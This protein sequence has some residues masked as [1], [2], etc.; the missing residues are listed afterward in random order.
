MDLMKNPNIHEYVL[1]IIFFIYGVDVIMNNILKFDEI[2]MKTAQQSNFDSWKLIYAMFSKSFHHFFKYKNN[3]S[4]YD[5]D[6]SGDLKNIT[7]DPPENDLESNA[8]FSIVKKARK[9]ELQIKTSG[10]IKWVKLINKHREDK[11]EIKKNILKISLIK[12][13]SKNERQIISL[14]NE[15][16]PINKSFILF[17]KKICWTFNKIMYSQ[18]TT[19]KKKLDSMILYNYY[20]REMNWRLDSIIKDGTM[21]LSCSIILDT[22]FTFIILYSILNY[23]NNN[24]ISNII[25]EISEIQLLCYASRFIDKTNEKK[26]IKKINKFIVNYMEYDIKKILEQKMIAIEINNATIRNKLKEKVF[27]TIGY[28]F[29]ENPM[30]DDGRDLHITICDYINSSSM[31]NIFGQSY[32]LKRNVLD[33]KGIKSY[34]SEILSRQSTKKHI[35]VKVPKSSKSPKSPRSPRIHDLLSYKTMIPKE[36]KLFEGYKAIYYHKDDN[37]NDSNN[38]ENKKNEKKNEYF[39]KK[40]I[41]IVQNNKSKKVLLLKFIYYFFPGTRSNKKEHQMIYDEMDK[42]LLSKQMKTRKINTKKED[43]LNI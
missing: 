35:Y 5:P 7:L 1:N 11:I 37:N 12:K 42:F 25:R 32:L 4:I 28:M 8:L 19:C 39:N 31:C 10:F 21:M 2:I 13:K 36:I 6:N 26:I 9:K 15:I 16:L 33:K 41:E 27:D 38:S 29:C 34:Y 24:D 3:F 30:L 22:L 20:L 40:I 43:R 14:S 23:T 17:T 18:S